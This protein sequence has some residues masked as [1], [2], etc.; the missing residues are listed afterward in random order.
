MIPTYS[1]S[2]LLPQASAAA[3]G[4]DYENLEIMVADDSPDNETYS[5]GRAG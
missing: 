1:Q 2:R 4:Q 5:A 3:A